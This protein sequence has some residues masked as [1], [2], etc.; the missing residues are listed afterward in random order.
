MAFVSFFTL[1]P[2]SIMSTPTTSNEFFTRQRKGIFII[3]K[4]IFN[5]IFF[6]VLK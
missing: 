5:S 2:C 6:N 3:G 4:I 1:T